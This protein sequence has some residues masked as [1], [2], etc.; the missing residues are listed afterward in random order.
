MKK[1]I[2]INFPWRRRRK[3]VSF[4]SSQSGFTIIE[5]MMSLVLLAIGAALSLPSYRAM[6][7]KR[8]LTHGAE[9]IMAFVNSAQSEAIKQNRIV[10]VSYVRS[11]DANWCVG[12]ITGAAAC[13]CRETVVTEADYCAIEAAP[14]ILNN[15]H[16]GNTDLVKS[17]TGGGV[18]SAY[19]FD[20][21]RGIFTDLDDS[22]VVA[23]SSNSADYKLD[24]MV[25]NTG[26]AILCSHDTDHSV[27]GYKV[28]AP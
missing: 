13:D 15:S 7:E 23:M 11:G 24:L 17:M 1:R 20:P 2:S 12:A 3:A 25:S 26:Q 19:S 22:L 6:M 4:F 9:Q 21:I 10:T 8:Q 14:R 27:P 16:V 5:L 28:C 18:D